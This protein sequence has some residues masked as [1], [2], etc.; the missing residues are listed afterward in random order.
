MNKFKEPIIKAGKSLWTTFPILIGIILL[1]S[2]VETFI[3]KTAFTYL[4]QGKFF[5]DP[6]IG[7]ILGSILAGNSITSYI[8]GGELITQGVSLIAVTAFIVSWVTVGLVQLP[9][10]SILLGKKFAIVRNITSFIFS[11]IVAILTVL[12]V[13]LL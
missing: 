1:I 11:I 7:S 2:L 4:F 8:L 13:S 6:L 10:E 3:P 5:L 12:V 9:A